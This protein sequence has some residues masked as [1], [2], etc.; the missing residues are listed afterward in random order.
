MSSV[1]RCNILHEL[2]LTLLLLQPIFFKNSCA[3]HS[4]MVFYIPW[5]SGMVD[6]LSLIWKQSA[7]SLMCRIKRHCRPHNCVSLII[8][9]HFRT[10]LCKIQQWLLIIIPVDLPNLKYDLKY[11]NQTVCHQHSVPQI[12]FLPHSDAGLSFSKS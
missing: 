5:L 6:C 2:T 12:P 8:F 4:D 7:H 10:S 1:T 9:F 3:V 11:S